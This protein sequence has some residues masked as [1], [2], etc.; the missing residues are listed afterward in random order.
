MYNDKNLLRRDK[1]YISDD[2]GI[3]GAV[4][5]PDIA[6]KGNIYKNDDVPAQLGFKISVNGPMLLKCSIAY[7]WGRTEPLTEINASGD[8]EIILRLP[9]LTDVF[10]VFR[11]D[12]TGF[13]L[14]G[15]NLGTDSIPF[16]HLRVGTEQFKKCGVSVHMIYHDTSDTYDCIPM[17]KDLG[18]RFVRDDFLWCFTETEKDKVVIP[19]NYE[20]TINA[21][22]DAGIEMNL[23]FL[24]GNQFHDEGNA[25]YT[26]EGRAAYA[27]Y[28]VTVLKHFGKK[29]R[30]CEI[31]NEYNLFGGFNPA[32]APPE[33]YAEML[34]TA[35]TEIKKECP[36]VEITAGVTCSPHTYW[37]KRMLD[38]GA[39]DYCDAISLHPYCQPT[40]PDDGQGNVE[41]NTRLFSNLIKKYGPEKPV[42]ISE[43]GWTTSADEN[44]ASRE[45]QAAS[46]TRLFAL[47][48]TGDAIYK[49][50]MY[51]FRDDGPN[52][53]EMEHHWGFIEGDGR[54]TPHAAK[55][56]YAAVS[57][58]NYMISG[59]ALKERRIWEKIQLMSFENCIL[60]WSLD[61]EK[62]VTFS[63]T[64][65]SVY[66]MYGNKSKACGKIKVN[67][68]PIYITG[69]DL[70]PVS[71]ENA[72]YKNTDFEYTVSLI[73]KFEGDKQ[74]LEMRLNSHSDML[75]GRIRFE[76]PELGIGC[77]Y[78]EFSLNCGENFGTTLEIPFAEVNKTY[79][80]LTDVSL[81]DG[82]RDMNFETVSF[83]KI[84]HAEDGRAV[85]SLS[86]P[87]DY[88]AVTSAPVPELS[89]D[90]S[91][92]YDS[93]FLYLNA[94][95]HDKT[96]LQLGSS[97][98]NWQDIWDGD[99]IEFCLQPLYDGN[100]NITR[101]NEI[102]I[103]KTSNTGED[104]AWRWRTVLDRGYGRY[105]TAKLSVERKGDATEYRAAFKWEEL[106][107]AGISLEDC[108]A[109]GFALRVGYANSDPR[110][111][112]GYMQLYGGIGSWRN[113]LAY[114]PMQFGLFSLAY[115]K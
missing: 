25:P 81:A 114:N 28:C 95:V 74:T 37:I 22:Y 41:E 87:D 82:R 30:H 69:T 58:L 97:N 91:L 16:S 89:A 8:D 11:I 64:D 100:K 17:I 12:I 13:D 5:T 35:Y 27:K 7:P 47:T 3:C 45:D 19:P 34:K 115:K 103:A 71:A 20:K 59:K 61:G 88:V 98:I 105:E 31:W 83:L 75:K 23:L 18:C 92:C 55:E 48:E 9:D 50:A 111:L 56:S 102:G 66:D 29:I 63:G 54:K 101:Y 78:S 40:Y 110:S 44:G 15:N 6:R 67:E 112:D 43:I 53:Y 90:I 46:L 32:G 72:P 73:P 33:T 4:I 77:G 57:Q 36:Y 113:P 99:Y 52:P 49:T 68:N 80:V 2:F 42:W 84:P 96:H 93:E 86:A 24:Y 94:D 104:V 14:S 108:Y 26:D 21:F 1:R 39:Y 65:I 109:F 107:P 70:K 38:A 62:Y 51:D 76:I 10:G 60:L 79:G 85:I 106:L